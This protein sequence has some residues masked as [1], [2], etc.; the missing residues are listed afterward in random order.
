MS[1]SFGG[2][3]CAIAIANAMAEV[4]FNLVNGY[5]IGYGGW[6]M[7]AVYFHD[8]TAQNTEYGFNVDSLNNDG[9]RIEKNYIIHPRK[10]GIVVGGEST[11]SNFRIL[12]NVVR[13]DKSGIIGIVFRGGVSGAVIADNQ[14]LAENASAAKS[15]AIRS[16]SMSAKAGANQN[17]YQSN[18]ITSGLKVVFEPGSQKSQNCFYGNR[19]DRGRTRDDLADNRDTPCS[20]KPASSQAK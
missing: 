14:V 19:D 5:P 4:R 7:G 11:F 20:A 13:M 2:T 8:N 3:G 1:Q 10:F 9:V 6:K 16:Y 15:T 18:Q 12:N 17:M